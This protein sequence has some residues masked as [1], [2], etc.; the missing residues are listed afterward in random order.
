MLLYLLFIYKIE[1][2]KQLQ[3]IYGRLDRDRTNDDYNLLNQ[4][5]I[6]LYL[7]NF[8]IDLEPNGRSFG[9]KSVG[10]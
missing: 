7:Y 10:K 3:W 2:K 5:E 1:A 8:P 4:T 9:S 6:R